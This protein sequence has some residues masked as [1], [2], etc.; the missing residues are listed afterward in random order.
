[1]K[2][3]FLS[4]ALIGLL[5]ILIIAGGALY[6]KTREL[7]EEKSAKYA[8]TE[9][10]YLFTPDG[11]HFD[12][13]DKKE[14]LVSVRPEAFEPNNIV[15][16]TGAKILWKAEGDEKCESLSDGHILI[17]FYNKNNLRLAYYT[18]E[19]E[20][21]FRY[22]CENYPEEKTGLIIIVK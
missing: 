16:K 3:E 1:M 12:L 21:Q 19:N 18:F 17:N 2:K 9:F 15:I 8:E 13:R 22:Y 6:L 7:E 5:A 10:S 11:R 14:I 20:G 4:G